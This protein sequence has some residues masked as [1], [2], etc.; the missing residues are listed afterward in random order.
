MQNSKFEIAFGSDGFGHV[1]KIEVDHRSGCVHV[2]GPRTVCVHTK[3]LQGFGRD[4]PKTECSVVVDHELAGGLQ[5]SVHPDPQH[6]RGQ[7]PTLKLTHSLR[8]SGI[9]VFVDKTTLPIGNTATQLLLWPDA[10]PAEKAA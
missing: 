9:L 3:V 6:L 8:D 2:S 7:V 10:A 4:A 1:V 5:V